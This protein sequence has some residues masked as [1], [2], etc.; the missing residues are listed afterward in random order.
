MREPQLNR[1]VS[2]NRAITESVKSDLKDTFY[3]NPFHTKRVPPTYKELLEAR[4]KGETPKETM[5]REHELLNKS[6]LLVLHK[7]FS[8]IFDKLNELDAEQFPDLIV[9]PDTAA[10]PLALGVKTMAD[11]IAAGK[12][13]PQPDY[14][15]AVLFHAEEIAGYAKALALGSVDEWTATLKLR[16][17]KAQEDMD[18]PDYDPDEDPIAKEKKIDLQ[19]QKIKEAWAACYERMCEIAR[20]T[21]H[22]TGKDEIKLLIVDEF[23]SQGRTMNLLTEILS[24]MS[25]DASLPRIQPSMFAFYSYVD[26]TDRDAAK[27]ADDEASQKLHGTFWHGADRNTD[28]S[29]KLYGCF[30]YAYANSW[31]LDPLEDARLAYEKAAKIGVRKEMGEKYS[32]PVRIRHDMQSQGIV[33]SGD[34]YR[35]PTNE[36]GR[37]LR[38]A[39]QDIAYDVL[40]KKFGI[41]QTIKEDEAEK[42]DQAA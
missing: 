17:S 14:R 19:I 6:D 11:I 16:L 36:D 20:H 21:A 13:K 40:D 32:I 27:R 7:G 10:R 12:D 23:F 42:L 8:A 39:I 31:S 33:Y 15:F 24:A 38:Q 9:F 30:Q 25:K 22:K 34:E 4:F 5:L 18:N 29:L 2:T 3:D 1:S 35:A 28:P 41:K 37:I 26:G